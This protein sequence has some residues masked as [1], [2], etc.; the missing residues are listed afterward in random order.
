M[1]PGCSLRH[2]QVS[3]NCP[4][5]EPHRSSPRPTSHFLK[6]NFNIILPST[7]GFPSVLF[8]SRFPTKTLHKPSPSPIPAT[9]PEHNFLLDLITRIIFGEEFKSL[10]SSLSS[11]LHSPVTSSLLGPNILKT[12]SS[13]VSPS[14]FA[15]K[16]H[17]HTKQ[18]Q[19]YGSVY[20]NFCIFR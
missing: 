1:E 8:P 4:S 16:F 17:T 5:P 15:T 6:I 9:C 10:S 18:Q 13:Y 3:A 19:N 12:P 14:M 7:L 20:L 11:F 2:S